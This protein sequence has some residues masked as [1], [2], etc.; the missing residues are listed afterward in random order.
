MRLCALMR[1]RGK[2]AGVDC[3]CRLPNALWMLPPTCSWS[4]FGQ[5][6]E[7]SCIKWL[8]FL[9]EVDQTIDTCCVG[10]GSI[11]KISPSGKNH[12]YAV[13]RCGYEQE[14]LATTAVWSYPCSWTAIPMVERNGD[15]APSAAMIKRVEICSP[16]SRVKV[17][18][19]SFSIWISSTL[20][21]ILRICL[22]KRIAWSR[23]NSR[24][25]AS[26][27]HA[28]SGRPASNAEKWRRSFAWPRSPKIC[29]SRTTWIR[30]W[31]SAS[32]TFSSFKRVFVLGARA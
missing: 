24:R 10:N 26:V 15:R 21:L 23:V 14:K 5:A 25:S 17:G 8:A 31:S 6:S 4:N 29:M 9:G 3:N 11:A 18:F 2:L 1:L 20:V 32:Q 19:V 13:W 7:R 12:W 22:W 27:I 16:L 28:N 30:W